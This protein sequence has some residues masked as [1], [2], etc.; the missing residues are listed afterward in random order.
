LAPEIIAR[1]IVEDLQA[2]LEQFGLI[3]SDLTGSYP[4]SAPENKR[5]ESIKETANLNEPKN[6]RT[7][8]EKLRTNV[9]AAQDQLGQGLKVNDPKAQEFFRWFGKEINTVRKAKGKPEIRADGTRGE[10]SDP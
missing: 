1:E 9:D 6:P 10:T 2:A 5:Q 4:V 7:A 8:M 3:E